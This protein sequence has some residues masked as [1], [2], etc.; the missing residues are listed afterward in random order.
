MTSS[1]A[2]ANRLDA[3]AK[4]SISVVIAAFDERRWPQ[5]VRAVDSVLEQSF[6]VAEVILVIDHNPLLFERAVAHYADIRV[7]ENQHMRGA[8]GAR[9]SGIAVSTGELVAFLD[10]DAVADVRWLATS[11]PHFSSRRVVGV[12]GKI[13]PMWEGRRPAWFPEEILWAVGAT[14]RGMPSVTAQVRNVWAGNMVVRRSACEA[15][16]GFRLD[17]GKRGDREDFQ[18]EDTE[19]CLRIADAEAG[20]TWLFEPQAI[21]A[22]HVPARR[23]TWPFLVAR[24][25]HE[26]RN[27]VIMSRLLASDITG[28]ERTYMLRTL[29]AGVLR[30]LSDLVHGDVTGVARSATI[31]CCTVAG[32]AGAMAGKLRRGAGVPGVVRRKSVPSEPGAVRPGASISRVRQ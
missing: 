4:P 26:G 12:G 1:Q 19:F 20:G 7:I 15:V 21:A 3:L 6:P 18:A 2:L 10:D 23:S 13:T 8:S 16:G 17:F 11:A 14:Y 32:L 5:T 29:P 31:A 25:F 9:N 24:C 22:H 30:G 28:R 27:K